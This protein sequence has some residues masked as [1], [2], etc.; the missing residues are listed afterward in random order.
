MPNIQKYAPILLFEIHTLHPVP[1]R[2][3]PWH[4]LRSY[5]LENYFYRDKRVYRLYLLF[6]QGYPSFRDQRTAEKVVLVWEVLR[7]DPVK[8]MV[9]GV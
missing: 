7:M 9:I 4:S 8:D 5:L 1:R 6:H 3:P 2:I